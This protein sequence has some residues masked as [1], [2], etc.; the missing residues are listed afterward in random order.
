MLRSMP[1]FT[2]R[3]ADT[4][5]P[6]QIVLVIA[7]TL[8]IAAAP[9]A[10]HAPDNLMVWIP[11][12]RVL[13]GGCAVRPGASTTLG[14]VAHADL[15]AWALALHRAADRYPAADVVVPG[16]GPPGGGDLLSHSISLL[17]RR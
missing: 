4:R 8:V 2:G 7:A 17:E 13:F 10:G 11:V 3:Y 15:A 6:R 12:Q 16:H 1:S 9:A 14:K 5:V